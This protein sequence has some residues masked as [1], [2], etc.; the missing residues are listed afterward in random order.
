MTPQDPHPDTDRPLVR[1]LA[2]RTYFAGKVTLNADA[3]DDL[4]EA[5]LAMGAPEPCPGCKHST[6]IHDALG[7]AY[8]Y[9]G[10]E[11][12]PCERRSAR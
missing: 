7:C 5:W 6:R 8:T 4:Y 10:G 12:C 3:F 1:R 2:S 9:S 11:P